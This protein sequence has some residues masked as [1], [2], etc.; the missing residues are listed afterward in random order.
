[1]TDAK[2][3]I[4][5]FEP[6][7]FPAHVNHAERCRQLYGTVENCKGAGFVTFD[8]EGNVACHGRS[9]SL[10][11]DNRGELDTTLIKIML[12]IDV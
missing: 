12:R 5:D 10:D 1:M 2:Y 3:I 11:V 8:G 4:V 9:E 7:I 6:D